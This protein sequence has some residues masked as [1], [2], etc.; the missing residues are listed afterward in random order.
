MS[1]LAQIRPAE[2]PALPSNVEAEAA[3][4]GAMLTNADLLRKFGADIRASDFY[5]PAHRRIFEVAQQLQQ[6]GPGFNLMTLKPILQDDEALKHLEGFSY[7][8]KLA[9]DG[10]G[11]LSP[12]ALA[13]QIKELASRR[14]LIEWHGDALSHCRDLSQPLR[15]PVLPDDIRPAKSGKTATPFTWRDP[16]TIPP[17]P[18][19][20]GRWLLLGT[21][22]CVVAPG[23]AG[24]STFMSALAASLATG[25]EILGKRLP[26]GRQRVWLWNLEDDLD[27]MARSI[28][29]AC[30]HHGITAQDLDGWLFLNSGLD[31]A[32]LCT[33]RDGRDGF[34]LDAAEYATV[35]AEIRKRAIN[36]L[37]IDPF[38]SS[39]QS[40]ESNNGRMDA[41][42]KSW[43]RV[44]KSTG[45]LIVLVHHVSKAGSSDVT[46]NSSRGAVSLIN[47]AR[48]VLVL[49]RMD[50]AEADRLGIPA[51]ERRRYVRIGDDKSNRA[52]ADAADWFQICSVD[53]GNGDNV[54]ALATWRLPGLFDDVTIDHLR[55][56]QARIA[57]RDWRENY[58]AASWC[59]RL[60]GEVLD[61]NV[62]E[63]AGKAKVTG[64]LR[65]WIKSG[66]L[67]VEERQDR[68][69]ELRKFVIMG[70]P[71]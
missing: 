57:E 21:V 3:L 60:I 45:C 56:V 26:L 18:W 44:A 31:G 54:G 5:A 46:A 22:A 13:N 10:R 49:N 68:N 29:A 62:D 59:G 32:D 43:A 39:H 33:A 30:L 11:H 41:I 64:I 2:A 16:A 71:A 70:D 24:K 66:A 1:T 53:L 7:I 25:R 12:D 27:E 23:G 6:Q 65:E 50:E 36:V 15:E 19:V 40:D 48:S 63:K 47:A 52:P 55:A 4:L 34:E 69:R 28:A 9:G 14:R 35:E 8:A 51:N 42:A 17:R 38:V 20:L 67:K 58:Q 61:I 37:V